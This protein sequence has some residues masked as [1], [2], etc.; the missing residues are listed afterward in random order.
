MTHFF[1]PVGSQDDFEEIGKL[2]PDSVSRL[3][4]FEGETIEVSLWGGVG[5]RVTA[6]P[7]SSGCGI[8]ISELPK[9]GDIRKFSVQGKRAGKWRIQ[10]GDGGFFIENLSVGMDVI[11]ESSRASQ[12]A[13]NIK[14]SPNGMSITNR[15]KWLTDVEAAMKKVKN[16]PVGLIVLNNLKK[17]VLIKPDT[18]DTTCNASASPGITIVITFVDASID[19]T[20]SLCIGANPGNAPDEILVHEFIHQVEDN[21]SDYKNAPNGVTSAPMEFGDPNNSK[22]GCPDF[23]TLT[24]TNVYS[25]MAGRKLRKDH[26]LYSE[27]PDVYKNDAQKYFLEFQLNFISLQKRRNAIYGQLKLATAPWNPFRDPPPP[28]AS[29]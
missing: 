6:T 27:L 2:A 5:L 10:T 18:V 3:R 16:N 12:F 7:E 24:I 15:R 4:I 28:P 13:S 9:A 14:L 22:Y 17:D 25:S 21:F 20:P 11:V 23:M 1:A 19:F 26:V 8:W 29:P